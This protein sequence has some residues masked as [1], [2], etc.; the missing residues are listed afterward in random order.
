VLLVLIFGPYDNPYNIDKV[1][2]VL[3]VGVIE[4]IDLELVVDK[5]V[6]YISV[7]DCVVF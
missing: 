1:D 7:V 5:P 4:Y 2:L 6:P 3:S